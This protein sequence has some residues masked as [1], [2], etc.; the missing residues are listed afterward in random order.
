M[1]QKAYGIVTGILFAVVAVVHLLRLIN[2]WDIQ[3]GTH[4]IPAIGSVIGLIV[5]AILSAWGF[6]TA[7]CGRCKTP[8]KS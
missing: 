2:H 5:T 3:V 6:S 7:C 1:R 8:A 4:T